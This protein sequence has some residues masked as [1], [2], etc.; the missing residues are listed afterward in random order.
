M[1]WTPWIKVVETAT[2]P[3]MYT[4]VGMFLPLEG[5]EKEPIGQRIIETPVD[6][7]ATEALRNPRSSFIAYVP[8]GSIKKGERLV[9]GHAKVTA[10]AVCHGEGLKGLGAAPG[11]AGRSP[12]YLVRQ[13]YDMQQGSRTGNWNEL[14]K[15]IVSGLSQEDMLN[16]AAYTSS[17][18]P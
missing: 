10:C 3:K 16:V 15:P 2:V 18:A 5:S 8:K 6:P 12:S 1:K 9:T 11:I 7:E 14:M 13:M 4:S 17:L